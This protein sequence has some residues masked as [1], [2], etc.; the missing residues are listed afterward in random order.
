[1][2]NRV[3]GVV[4]PVLFQW[5][6]MNK[7]EM[8]SFSILDSRSV[9]FLLAPDVSVG[10]NSRKIL[11][12]WLGSEFLDVKG[13]SQ[14]ISI[15]GK[16]DSSNLHWETVGHNFLNHMGLPVDIPVQVIFHFIF[17]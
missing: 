5:P 7:L 4:T 9:Y 12:V 6:C 3:A 10:T 13:Q 14:L 1:M 15:D 11:F 2:I 16:W 17:I 8:H